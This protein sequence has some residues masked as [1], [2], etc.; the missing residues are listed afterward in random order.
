[1]IDF[2]DLSL[3]D[4][5][6]TLY[7]EGE[8]I[9]S[10]RYYKYKVNLYLLEGDYFE[11]FINHKLSVVEKILPLDWDNSRLKFYTDQIDLP[12]KE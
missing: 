6:K 9:M 2:I 11:V 12:K 3:N 5:I 1:M 10:I 7:Q 4:K 8:F